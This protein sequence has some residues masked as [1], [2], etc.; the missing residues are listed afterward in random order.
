MMSSVSAVAI[1]PLKRNQSG[2]SG[3][4]WRTEGFIAK[5][6]DGDVKEHHFIRADTHSSREDADAC[7]VNK[8]K[9]II[10]ESGERVFKDA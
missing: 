5:E 7:A 9:R 4:Q 8:A 10:D 6:L 2:K 3:A 1:E